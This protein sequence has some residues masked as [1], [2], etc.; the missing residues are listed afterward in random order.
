[1][2]SSFR[3]QLNLT[4]CCRLHPAAIR[5]RPMMDSKSLSDPQVSA[6]VPRPFLFFLLRFASECAVSGLLKL[7]CAQLLL[8]SHALNHTLQVIR[9]NFLFTR[10]RVT[11]F[12]EEA[13]PRPCGWRVCT[14]RC[15][16]YFIA[17]CL[18]APSSAY[19]YF[20][21]AS[22]FQ[23]YFTL[24]YYKVTAVVKASVPKSNQTRR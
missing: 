6:H 14:L 12:W 9:P 4:F 17:V 16:M 1:M 24:N 11:D 3:R 22:A 5:R 15:I 20:I 23:S 8:G 19:L 21:P 13:L 2:Y 18:L 10:Y 7:S